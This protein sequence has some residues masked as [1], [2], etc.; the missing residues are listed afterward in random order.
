MAGGR[1]HILRLLCWSSLPPSVGWYNCYSQH[2]IIEENISLKDLTTFKL[3]G[4]ARYFMR[5][6][7]LE[8]IKGACAWAASLGVPL[9]VLEEGSNI[10]VSDKGFSGLVLKIELKC[11]TY[12]YEKNNFLVIALRQ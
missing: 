3:G 12:S 4:K 9:F 2:M 5:A 8:D 11:I 10:L 6:Y 1:T 7:T